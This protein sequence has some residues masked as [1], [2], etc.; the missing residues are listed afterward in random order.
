M[1]ETYINEQLEEITKIAGGINGI[2]T[3]EIVRMC[4]NIF[5]DGKI[6]GQIEAQELL[7]DKI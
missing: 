5:L 4:R 1:N 2:A 6:K 3:K 7:K